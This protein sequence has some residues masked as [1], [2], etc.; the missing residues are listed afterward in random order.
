MKYSVKLTGGET[1][2]N[3]SCKAR[4]FYIILFFPNLNK[5]FMKKILMSF[6][7]VSVVLTGWSS[8]K[9]PGSNVPNLNPASAQFGNPFSSFI[10]HRQGHSAI[11][12]M[13]QISSSDNVISFQVQRSY[14]GEF[15]DPVSNLSCGASKRFT[16][17]DE[18]VFPGYIYYRIEVTLMDGTTLYS[19][20][21]T[22]HIVQK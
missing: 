10:A 9:K 15:F 21:E 7:L 20:V 22:V 2:R 8:S 17:E 5:Y 4:R 3:P 6:I 16:W 12:L 14:D 18:N 11:G 13:W 19:K 1:A